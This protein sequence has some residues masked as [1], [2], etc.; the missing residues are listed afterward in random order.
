MGLYATDLTEGLVRSGV[1]FRIAHRRTGELLQRLGDEGRSLGDL[2]ASEWE[3]YGLP[4]GAGF[5]DPDRAVRV[6][7]G[8]GGPAP[9]AVAE[10][11]TELQRLLEVDRS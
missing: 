10:Q 4:D 9:A 6:R 7:D 5:L 3:A 8:R 11:I 1:P 2:T